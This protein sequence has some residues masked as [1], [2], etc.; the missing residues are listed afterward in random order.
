MPML[1][2]HLGVYSASTSQ[3]A[4]GVHSRDEPPFEEIRFDPLPRIS[5]MKVLI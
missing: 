5:C 3:Q 4:Q 1:P 2:R